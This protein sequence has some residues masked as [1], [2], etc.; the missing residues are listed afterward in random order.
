MKLLQSG[1]KSVQVWEK[2]TKTTENTTNNEQARQKIER[3]K[4]HKARKNGKLLIGA[5]A[6][7]KLHM[8]MFIIASLNQQFIGKYVKT[9]LNQKE[10]IS[11]NSLRIIRRSMQTIG[12]NS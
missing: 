5:Q 12:K 7:K 6:L 11:C 1:Q 8:L 2:Q 10:K 4:T 9:Q 3:E